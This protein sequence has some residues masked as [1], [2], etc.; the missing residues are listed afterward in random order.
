MQPESH[1]MFS[2]QNQKSFWRGKK[3][4]FRENGHLTSV[5]SETTSENSTVSTL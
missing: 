1:V 2:L 5:P 3:K 4:L